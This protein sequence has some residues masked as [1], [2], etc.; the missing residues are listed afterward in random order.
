MT[1]LDSSVMGY[2]NHMGL[3]ANCRQYFS[4]M[5]QS[6]FT[7]IIDYFDCGLYKVCWRDRIK[8]IAASSREPRMSLNIYS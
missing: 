7:S 1:R 4:R 6:S 8:N 5:T 2:V 3:K